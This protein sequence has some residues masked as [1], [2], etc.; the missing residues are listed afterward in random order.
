MS[1]LNVQ[2]QEI[3]VIK[4]GDYDF[5]SLTNMTSSF[6]DSASLIERWIRNKDTIE[7]LGVWESLNNNS[8]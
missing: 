7:F 4:S 5:I 1:I 6:D 8:F 2:G 3:K